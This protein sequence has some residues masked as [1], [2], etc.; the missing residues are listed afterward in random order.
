MKTTN[1]LE[2]IFDATGKLLTSLPATVTVMLILIAG[3]IFHSQTL[4][5]RSYPADMAD[6]EKV[7]ASWFV[8]IGF[9]FTVL[10][11]TA[12]ADKLPGIRIGP[13]RGPDQPT[14]RVPIPAVF[15]VMT[16]L[17]V[18]FF[19]EGH[20]FE[21]P[22]HLIL[23]RA[24]IAVIFAYANLTY[25]H[26]FVRHWNARK[27]FYSDRSHLTKKIAELTSRVDHLTKQKGDLIKRNNELTT[28]IPDLT[29]QV[30]E[31]KT[32]LH[33]ATVQRDRLEAQKNQLTRAVDE[34]QGRL[35]RKKNT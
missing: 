25:A 2:R 15:A 19:L 7:V 27:N 13:E 1:P 17:I 14:R 9:E 4:F 34:L 5:Y 31:L 22:A 23:T 29:S 28:Q 16:A 10:L 32:D 18:W 8:A 30:G 6:W 21:V 12:N 26:L 3:M 24:L 20:D 11:T 35:S 33:N